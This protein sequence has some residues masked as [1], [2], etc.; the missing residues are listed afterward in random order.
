MGPPISS[1]DESSRKGREAAIK[2]RLSKI[3]KQQKI[4]QDSITLQ[5]EMLTR[6]A[7]AEYQTQKMK[8]DERRGKRQPLA[9]FGST[10]QRFT[11]AWSQFMKGHAGLNDAMKGIDSQYG[12]LASGALAVLLQVRVH[13]PQ[14]IAHGSGR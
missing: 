10:L 13:K 6:D 14:P 5:K 7:V 12:G 11:H 3:T 1:A 4:S 9:K 8:L 2:E